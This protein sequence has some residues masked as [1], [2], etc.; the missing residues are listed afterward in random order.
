MTR[1]DIHDDLWQVLKDVGATVQ[2]DGNILFT[3]IGQLSEVVAVF[4]RK[5]VI[6]QQ[7]R[8]ESVCSSLA[9]VND[10]RAPRVAAAL[11]ECAGEIRQLGH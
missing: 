9:Q 1:T 10:E 4:A 6:E 2:G 7:K 11:R 5:A 8:C 3:N